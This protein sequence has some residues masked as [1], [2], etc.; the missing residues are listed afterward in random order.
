MSI[1][2]K[3]CQIINSSERQNVLISNGLIE[4]ISLKVQDA[5]QVIDC[6]GLILL[7]GVIDAHVHFRVP[8][9]EYK[10][11]FGTGSAAAAH[12]GVTTVIEMPNTNPA[13]TTIEL[14]QEKQSLAKGSKINILSH[15]G[16]T[17]NNLAELKR[18]EVKSIKIYVGSTTGDL[19]LSDYQK[20]EQIMCSVDKLFVFHAEDESII[21]ENLEKY[22]DV[23]DPAVHSK[24]RPREA[25]IKATEKI[26]EIV[27]RT[28]RR[29]HFA[30]LSAKEEVGLIKQ[31]KQAGLPI[32]CEVTPHH[33]FLSETD[34]PRLKNFAKVNPPLRTKE[35]QDALWQALL[36][37]TIDIVASDHAPHTKDEKEEPYWHAPAGVPGIE[38]MLPLLLNL[39]KQKKISLNRVREITSKAPA[40]I[41]GLKRKGEVKSGYD[42]DLALIDMSLVK[43]VKNEILKTKCGWSPFAGQRLTGWPKLT[44][45]RGNI[46]F[47]NLSAWKTTKKSL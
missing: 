19:L 20:I 47:N 34:Y 39:V 32:T 44:I 5:D 42:A 41:F 24:A 1:L 40:R 37:G 13:T 46:I 9:A 26:I 15:F 4:K 21:Q 33:L 7:P 31:A 17:A 38:T 18:P 36:D 30:H 6:S 12:A 22:K 29:A 43:E 35:D 14:L 28:G 27:K 11:D 25:V 2:L 23:D 10:E 16:A 3:N 8:G 45:C